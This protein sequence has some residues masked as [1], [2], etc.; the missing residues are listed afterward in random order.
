MLAILK[1]AKKV[2]RGIQL[3]IDGLEK[4]IDLLILILESK[5]KRSRE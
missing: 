5:K 1:T 2:V 4:T 3:A